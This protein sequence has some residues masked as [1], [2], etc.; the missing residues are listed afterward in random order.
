MV[1]AAIEARHYAE[2]EVCFEGTFTSCPYCGIAWPCDT[3]IVLAAYDDRVRAFTALA[4]KT[5]TD[6]AK[7]SPRT[8]W[9]EEAIRL[10]QS[11]LTL[12]AIGAA[13]GVSKERVSQVLGRPGWLPRKARPV[14][15]ERLAHA[16][17]PCQFSG[18]SE[19][20]GSTSLSRRFCAKHVGRRGA[21][22]GA[23]SPER[24]AEHRARVSRW[25]QDH[26]ERTKEIGLE[27][28]RAYRARQR[29]KAV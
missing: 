19:P 20:I 12:A 15:P 9:R 22:Y 26:P 23:W 5:R 7:M 1:L 13:V 24:K 3:A 16:A 8:P 25:Q 2:Y 18:C 27:A 4:E 21:P 29:A 14:S 11:G 28:N 10:R 6:F 17:L